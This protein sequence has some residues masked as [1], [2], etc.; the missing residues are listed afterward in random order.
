MVL[1]VAYV[2]TFFVIQHQFKQLEPELR[3]RLE[4]NVRLILVIVVQMQLF[5]IMMIV[6]LT[7]R[8]IYY[9]VY[10]FIDFRLSE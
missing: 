6:L 7:T 4:R 2:S 3:G 5:F 10:R 1:A 8:S 9:A